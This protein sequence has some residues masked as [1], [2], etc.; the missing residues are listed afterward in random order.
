MLVNLGEP[1]SAASFG[2]ALWY[3]KVLPALFPLFSVGAVSV[4]MLG[5]PSFGYLLAAGN[6]LSNL[7]S[8]FLWRFRSYLPTLRNIA[9]TRPGVIPAQLDQ[10]GEAVL[11]IG[12]AFRELFKPS[13][14]K[15]SGRG[16][17]YCPVFSI[18]Q[19]A[20]ALGNYRLRSGCIHQIAFPSGKKTILWHME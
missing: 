19:S 3:S 20:F 9:Q 18:K 4:G 13:L 11:G 16:W 12:Q 7:I 8:V 14:K 6:Y 5:R 1:I 2:F 17:F 15:H 10:K